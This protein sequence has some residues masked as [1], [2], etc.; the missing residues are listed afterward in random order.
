[1]PKLI[2]DPKT[3]GAQLAATSPLKQAARIKR[4]VLMAYGEED[5]RVPLPHGTKMRDALRAAGNQD[6]EWV[7]Y[8]SEG[9]HFNLTKNNV[10]LWT[11]VE[12]FLGKH[13]K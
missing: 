5:L 2:G 9:H 10:D 11:R 13:S 7:Q 6:V 1:M 8:P 12:A 3:D 4:P